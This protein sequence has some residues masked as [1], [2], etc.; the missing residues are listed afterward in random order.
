MPTALA[1]LG[2]Q[3]R[4]ALNIMQRH[5]YATGAD[6]VDLVR[7]VARHTSLR[8]DSTEYR[9][10]A[11]VR[12]TG[13]PSLSDLQSTVP[14]ATLLV[15]PSELGVEA[16]RIDAAEGVR[17]AVDELLNPHSAT[18]KLGSSPS[19]SILTPGSIGTTASDGSGVKI[20]RAFEKELKRRFVRLKA[21]WVGP[22]AYRMFSAGARL[23]LSE[24]SPP[25][26]DLVAG[27]H[28]V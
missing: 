26:F 2:R 9:R 15:T 23:T 12:S 7:E 14:R 24:Q 18:L 6:L 16:K 10:S 3:L 19:P 25:Q 22:E 1:F 17:F 21:Y 11:S 27:G 13:M 8:Y 4:P 5:F 28:D 20:V